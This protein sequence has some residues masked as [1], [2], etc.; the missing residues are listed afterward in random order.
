MSLLNKYTN[1]LYWIAMAGLLFWF[2]YSKGWILANFQSIDA[3][4]AL[5]LAEN[6]SNTSVLDVRTIKEYKEGHLR[7]AMLIPVQDLE[8]NLGMLRQDKDKKIIVYCATGNRSVSASRI[9]EEK[10][11]TP[12]NVKG[13]IIELKNAGATLIR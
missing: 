7:D 6:D 8:N 12:L 13:G 3:K 5:H 9:L 11:F 10:G 2:V 1:I 4:Q